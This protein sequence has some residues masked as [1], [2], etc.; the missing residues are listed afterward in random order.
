MQNVGNFLIFKVRLHLCNPEPLASF[1]DDSK[2][3]H[4]LLL[5]VDHM[6]HYYASFDAIAERRHTYKQ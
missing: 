3:G 5:I 2:L 1:D 6:N 4:S